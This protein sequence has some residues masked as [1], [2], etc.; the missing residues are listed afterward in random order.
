MVGAGELGGGAVATRIDAV[1]FDLAAMAG[2]AGAF[3]GG[4][5]DFEGIERVEERECVCE[6]FE[7]RRYRGRGRGQ[8]ERSV[9]S[10]GSSRVEVHE[11]GMT[12]E[13]IT[14]K[15]EGDIE[16]VEDIVLLKQRKGEN[17]GSGWLGGVQ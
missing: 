14:R 12:L 6:E 9:R 3:D 13:G 2:V 11:G 10:S 17:L 16:D 5:H 4:R 1:A 15:M 8:T 7:G